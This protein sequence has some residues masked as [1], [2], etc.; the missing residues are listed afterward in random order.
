MPPIETL[1]WFLHTNAKLL[2][3]LHNEPPVS[4]FLTFVHRSSELSQKFI[5]NVSDVIKNTRSVSTALF[6]NSS[7]KL[8][9]N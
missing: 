4:E 6:S 9:S 8:I 1:S 7:Y 3:D 2:I 5:E